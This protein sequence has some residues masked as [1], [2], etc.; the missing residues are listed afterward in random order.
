MFS[1]YWRRQFLFP[2]ATDSVSRAQIG[3]ASHFDRSG[4]RGRQCRHI[5]GLPISI[6]CIYSFKF[7]VPH[8]HEHLADVQDLPGLHGIRA[9]TFKA[10]L[11]LQGIRIR[12]KTRAGE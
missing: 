6:F 2:I 4:T 1:R 9:S 7:V 3:G 5:T 8:C 10:M 12:K 11:D